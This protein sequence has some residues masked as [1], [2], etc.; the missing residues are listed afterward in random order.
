M[1]PMKPTRLD[2]ADEAIIAASSFARNRA[3]QRQLLS[4]LVVFI[5]SVVGSTIF[6]LT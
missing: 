1:K 2:E 3:T 4:S 6:S 5:I